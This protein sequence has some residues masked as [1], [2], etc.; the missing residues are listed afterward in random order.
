MRLRELYDRIENCNDRYWDLHKDFRKLTGLRPE[1]ME[2]GYSGAKVIDFCRQL[3][4][5]AFRGN[6]PID[7]EYL[8]MGAFMPF[9]R[10]GLR[11]CYP[12][13]VAPSFYPAVSSLWRLGLACSAE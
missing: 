6:Y 13:D 3:L 4:S 9:V 2:V 11:S 8:M 5:H 10:P 7:T 12:D 1:F